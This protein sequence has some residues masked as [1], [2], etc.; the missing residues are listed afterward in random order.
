MA[1]IFKGRVISGTVAAKL[2][3]HGM[4]VVERVLEKTVCIIVNVDKKQLDKIPE[5]GT[6]HANNE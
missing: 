2:L 1:P 6:I 4:N 5:R 3:K